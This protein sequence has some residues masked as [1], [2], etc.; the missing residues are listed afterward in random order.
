MHSRGK[1]SQIWGLLCVLGGGD[2]QS[3]CSREKQVKENVLKSVLAGAGGASVVENPP[4][5]DF[6]LSPAP[7][8]R[9]EVGLILLVP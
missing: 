6:W 5:R 2:A 8:E 1:S 7:R 3:M 9:H 4:L